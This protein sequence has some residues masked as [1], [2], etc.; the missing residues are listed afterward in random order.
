MPFLATRYPSSLLNLVYLFSL[1]A[2]R[3]CGTVVLRD[4]DLQCPLGPILFEFLFEPVRAGVHAAAAAASIRNTNAIPR[5]P[6]WSVFQAVRS[7]Y[8]LLADRRETGA[9]TATRVAWGIRPTKDAR[10]PMGTLSQGGSMLALVA[11]N[12]RIEG[13]KH[14][15]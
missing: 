1:G 7:F 12:I 11:H 4:V 9:A 15:E 13:L 3:A 8:F 10:R 5:Q 6:A 2:P 14:H